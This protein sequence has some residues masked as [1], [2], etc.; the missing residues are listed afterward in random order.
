MKFPSY[1]LLELT[2]SYKLAFE[3]PALIP[4]GGCATKAFPVTFTTLVIIIN[5]QGKVSQCFPKCGT[6]RLMVHEVILDRQDIK[7]PVKLPSKKSYFQY[8][9]IFLMILSGKISG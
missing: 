1:F 2:L 5:I 7:I 8:L 9:L 3:Q 6:R 4:Q